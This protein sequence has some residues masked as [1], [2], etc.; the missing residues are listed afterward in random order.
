M[1]AL[2]LAIVAV[3]FVSLDATGSGLSGAHSGARG[4]LGSLYRGTD[5][6]VG[7]VRRFV[8]G[9][10]DASANRA[11]VE[12]LTRE[13][14]ALAAKVAAQQADA[15]TTQRLAALQLLADTGNYPI[16]AAKVTA[17]GPGQGFDW[18]VSIDVGSSSGIAVNQTVTD[19]NN[20]IG[21]VLHVNSGSSVV[22]LGADPQSGVGVRDVR[23][24]ELAVAT[25][26][27]THGYTVTP[28]DPQADL[29]AGDLLRTGPAG[30]STYTS[31][32][33]VATV[34]SVRKASD[35]SVIAQAK[36]SIDPT[37]LDVLGV[38]SPGTTANAARAPLTPR[39][40]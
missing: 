15:A 20:L 2:V 30:Q 27:G 34:T 8:Q 36:S 25:G 29:R 21:R 1:A 22:L 26:D 39:G 7:P 33:A 10:P 35:G 24:G 3:G 12:Q 37:A 6:V 9:V 5:A 40:R 11:K 28:L 38:I 4:T 13:N 23:N 14:A 17:F 16:V 18:T 19:G 32:L 31:G